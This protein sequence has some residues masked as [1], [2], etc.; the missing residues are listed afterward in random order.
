[1]LA[2]TLSTPIALVDDVT[3]LP[4]G[5]T[6]VAPSAARTRPSAIKPTI[7]MGL[8]VRP[9]SGQARRYRP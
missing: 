9:T 6:A 1:M 3:A 2:L 8:F 5:E 7:V 4:C